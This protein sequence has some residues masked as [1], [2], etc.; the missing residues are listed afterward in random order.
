MLGTI[1]SWT[2]STIVSFLHFGQKSGK[3]INTVSEYIFVFV[4][5]LQTGH[6]THNEIFSFIFYPKDYALDVRFIEI[7]PIG[8][9]RDYE[10][11]SSGELLDRISKVYPDYEWSNGYHGNGP[12][13][14]ITIPGFKL[15]PVLGVP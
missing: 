3:R 8:H 6:G 11:I 15:A 7:M 2:T 12:A 1:L 5:P 9:G 13:S 14:Y 10:G 4:F